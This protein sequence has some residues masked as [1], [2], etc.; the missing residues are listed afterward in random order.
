MSID[1]PTL[2]HFRHFRHFSS[3]LTNEVRKITYEKIN[4]FMQNEPNFRKSQVNVTDLLKSN[5]EQMD[6]WSI[7]KN[8]PKTNPI[9]ANKR[10]IRTQFKPKQTQF[11]YTVCLQSP[12]LTLR[13][14]NNRMNRFCYFFSFAISFDSAKMALYKGN[15]NVNKYGRK[16]LNLLKCKRLSD[17]DLFWP[18]TGTLFAHLYMR[19]FVL[20]N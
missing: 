6:T 10:P 1:N 12:I 8:E 7:R 18:L 4:L 2:A 11:T 16:K 9:L 14:L 13:L 20:T 15:R 19:I 17:P 3:L 5:Y